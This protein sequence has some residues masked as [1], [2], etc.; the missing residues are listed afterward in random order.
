[1]KREKQHLYRITVGLREVYL[2]WTTAK[3][4]REIA[5]SYGELRPIIKKLK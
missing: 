3:R 1:M 2:G 5:L 4:V